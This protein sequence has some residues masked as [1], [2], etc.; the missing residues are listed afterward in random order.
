MNNIYSTIKTVAIGGTMTVKKS[1]TAEE[2]KQIA[3]T[4]I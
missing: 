4:L 3:V 1:F 2:A